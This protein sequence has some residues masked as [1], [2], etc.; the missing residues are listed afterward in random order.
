MFL[1]GAFLAPSGLADDGKMDCQERLLEQAKM[2]KA[3]A[4]SLGIE[5]RVWV[6][7][8]LVMRPSVSM[9]LCDL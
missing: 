1:L 6:Y 8:N 9:R 4:R 7:R 2:T 3:H 5:Q